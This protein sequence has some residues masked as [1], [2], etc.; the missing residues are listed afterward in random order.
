[1]L[2]NL[3]APVFAAPRLVSKEQAHEIN[4]TLTNAYN[5]N[6]TT[7]NYNAA[8]YEKNYQNSL[9]ELASV[10]DKYQDIVDVINKA[11][12]IEMLEASD[13]EILN[14]E[15]LKAEK[16]IIKYNN[17]LETQEKRIE[18]LG[19]MDKI[20]Q[21][22]VLYQN[23]LALKPDME[24]LRA[25]QE[26]IVRENK[27]K[28][29]QKDIS[30]KEKEQAKKEIASAQEKIREYNKNYFS[31][32]KGFETFNKVFNEMLKSEEY[33]SK[34]AEKFQKLFEKDDR[35]ENY[36]RQ[37][38]EEMLAQLS[39]TKDLTADSDWDK[40][41]AAADKELDKL[42]PELEAAKEKFERAESAQDN[43]YQKYLEDKFEKEFSPILVNYCDY[44]SKK[45]AEYTKPAINGKVNGHNVA[46]EQGS[47]MM[48]LDG[49]LVAD[50]QSNLIWEK[51][52]DAYLACINPS[53]DEEKLKS[54]KATITMKEM[55][56]VKYGEYLLKY[57]FEEGKN[58]SSGEENK[59]GQ[60]LA[61]KNIGMFIID[62]QRGLD[63][64]YTLLGDYNQSKK[65]IDYLKHDWGKYGTTQTNWVQNEYGDMDNTDTY[66]LSSSSEE[67]DALKQTYTY[68]L[69]LYENTRNVLRAYF[70][71]LNELL[72]DIMYHLAQNPKAANNFTG[73]L[74]S[75]GISLT[76]DFLNI[77]DSLINQKL[78]EINQNLSREEKE[79]VVEAKIQK[80]PFDPLMFALGPSHIVDRNRTL[81]RE[82]RNAVQGFDL[83]NSQP[84]RDILF[85]NTLL[86]TNHR[87]YKANLEAWN[88][89]AYTAYEQKA[90]QLLASMA[91]L[92]KTLNKNYEKEPQ[93]Y[94]NELEE[95]LHEYGRD[96]VLD[97]GLGVLLGGIT[98]I[99]NS[100]RSFVTSTAKVLIKNSIKVAF[101]S[102]FKHGIKAVSK[103]SLTLA[104]LGAKKSIKSMRQVLNGNFKSFNANALRKPVE[105]TTRGNINT[106]RTIKFKS[107]IRGTG[108]TLTSD[109]TVFKNTFRNIQSKHGIRPSAAKTSKMFNPELTKKQYQQLAQELNA[110]EKAAARAPEVKSIVGSAAGK[111]TPEQVAQ[112]QQAF[113]RD[114]QGAKTTLFGVRGGKAAATVVPVP[115]SIAD[116]LMGNANFKQLLN[117][118]PLTTRLFNKSIERT[119]QAIAQGLNLDEAK[120]FFIKDFDW[121]LEMSSIIPEA[122]RAN[123]IEEVSK[124][125]D[126]F[127]SNNGSSSLLGGGKNPRAIPSII[128]N[129][130]EGTL[131]KATANE[132]KKPGL[133]SNMFN[134]AKNMFKKEG[135]KTAQ[136]LDKGS[137]NK[138]NQ[139][140]EGKKKALFNNGYTQEDVDLLVKQGVDIENTSVRD[141]MRYIDRSLGDNSK[142][143][144]L[145]LNSNGLL[146]RNKIANTNALLERGHKIEDI[147]DL[148]K[149]YNFEKETFGTLDSKMTMEVMDIIEDKVDEVSAKAG[150]PAR[151]QSSKSVSGQIKPAPVQAK[152]KYLAAK[153]DENSVGIVIET[154]S[155]KKIPITL[156]REELSILSRGDIIKLD[157][158][159]VTLNKDTLHFLEDVAK[160]SP[161][162]ANHL[163]ATKNPGFF[164]RIFGKNTEANI[165]ENLK[166]PAQAY[167]NTYQ[168]GAV[169]LNK[170]ELVRFNGNGGKPVNQDYIQAS[171]DARKYMID[172][173]ESGRYTASTDSYIE[174]MNEMHK[175]S[176][177]GKS[178]NLDWY[179]DAGN[180]KMSVNPG[181]IRN[182]GRPRNSRIEQATKVEE[183]AKRYN[184]PFRVKNEYATVD[185]AAIPRNNLPVNQYTEGRFFHYYPR[186]GDALRPY[187]QQMQRTAK[188]A[189]SLINQQA[190]EREI[191]E[192]IAEHYQYAANARPYGQI[193]NSLFMNEVNTLLQKAGLRP[194]PHGELDIAA[195]HLQPNTFKKYFVDTY[196]KTRLP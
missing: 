189:V 194:M 100:I 91:S 138:V 116:V 114:L 151:V 101:K 108:R 33:L 85:F 147:I 111:A 119:N 53:W 66:T 17:T 167:K 3:T 121:R 95:N 77:D 184:D 74:N 27:E 176:A 47:V 166:T 195:M 1:M 126:A 34:E 159:D 22:Y 135:D 72:I 41:F 165:A 36:V 134:K 112:M 154:S 21:R 123:I 83:D 69:M 181:Q 80:R 115:P 68:R 48:R 32:E 163:R 139:K 24:K 75:I 175:V 157:Y 143:S 65:L 71:E 90:M 2:F 16:D 120:A 177:S 98:S 132:A 9:K 12:Q 49:S 64:F 99:V 104:K 46:I 51:Q 103:R 26:N 131:S 84:I 18:K 150:T 129:G 11:S 45:A 10:S 37:A 174:T 187:Y 146:E 96:M 28:L 92:G 137:S 54:W 14:D 59:M 82:R 4:S 105:M 23:W 5:N 50:V 188:E 57:G 193:N 35:I 141:L 86:Q 58:L 196:Y 171:K 153:A 40:I 94:Y 110:Y 162:I 62:P 144:H 136:A 73:Y 190:P 168:G 20:E 155:G 127:S 128:E 178:G 31:Q 106:F 182:G 158:A 161:E 180:G 87:V 7:S 156:S 44:V 6:S 124:G 142:L 67:G 117:R 93:R 79:S 38:K 170:N 107:P 185:L 130:G 60:T 164:N 89:L 102:S 39:D 88:E 43:A 8:Y 63:Y 29:N 118:N 179:K 191:I 125:L 109:N 149:K 183:V 113:S 140:V 81:V 148:S 19:G 61:L 42:T 133:F 192:K 122:R 172:A 30:R 97:I 25:E 169:E 160:I 186:G 55:A 152:P 76:K 173:V 78:E 13:L 56:D 70:N 145:R 15:L 52:K